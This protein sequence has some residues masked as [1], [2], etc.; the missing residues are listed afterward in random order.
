M[1]DFSFSVL[2]LIYFDSIMKNFKI[3]HDTRDASQTTAWISSSHFRMD[4]KD[5]K[6]S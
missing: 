2:F 1:I 3:G 5:Y 4:F 6:L